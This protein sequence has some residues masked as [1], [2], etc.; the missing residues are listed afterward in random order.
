MKISDFGMSRSL[1]DSHYYRIRGRFVLPVCW[2]AFECWTFG[3]TMWEIFTLIREQPYNDMSDKQ[4]I[5][6]A[7]KD[8]NRLKVHKI[9]WV[10]G[11]EQ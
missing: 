3:V 2:I 7:F 8:M 10:H 5:E 6:D 4:V 11:P 9:C 1:Y